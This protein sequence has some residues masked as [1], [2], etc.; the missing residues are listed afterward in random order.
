[1]AVDGVVKYYIDK[2]MNVAY[3][4][5]DRKDR[6]EIIG[7]FLKLKNEKYLDCGFGSMDNWLYYGGTAYIR[8]D[9][10]EVDTRKRI[11]C[12]K[13]SDRN[14]YMPGGYYYESEKRVNRIIDNFIIDG[15]FL[16]NS[17]EEVVRIDGIIYGTNGDIHIAN[18]YVLDENV[19]KY[20][21]MKKIGEIDEN[22]LKTP[23]ND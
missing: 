6:E 19:K 1:M 23:K 11:N 4:C 22:E 5:K 9:A 12:G 7:Q 16:L 13:A 15:K 20:Q 8:I 18:Q 2:R 14:T 17:G 10:T 3:S 21:I